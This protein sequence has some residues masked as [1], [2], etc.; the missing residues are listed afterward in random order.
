MQDMLVLS[1]FCS[2]SLTFLKYKYKYLFAFEV[3]VVGA[4]IE[5]ENGVSLINAYESFVDDKFSQGSQ[6][7]ASTFSMK[8]MLP[9]MIHTVF[10]CRAIINEIPRVKIA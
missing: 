6:A 2:Y 4:K 8:H 7:C 9:F 10:F 5:A 1:L 3:I